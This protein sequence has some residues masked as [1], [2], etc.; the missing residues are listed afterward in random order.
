MASDQ[1]LDLTVHVLDRDPRLVSGTTNGREWKFYAVQGAFVGEED[2][3]ER[4]EFQADADKVP[5]PGYYKVHRSS[6][7]VVMDKGGRPRLMISGKLRLVPAAA[8]AK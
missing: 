1:T 3:K 2:V 7:S 5:A 6:V 4:F 8:P